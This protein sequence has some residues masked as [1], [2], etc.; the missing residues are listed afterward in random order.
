ME[1]FLRL[2]EEERKM[3]IIEDLGM[4]Y[5]YKKFPQMKFKNDKI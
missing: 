1:Q 3:K 2:P 4:D 5:D